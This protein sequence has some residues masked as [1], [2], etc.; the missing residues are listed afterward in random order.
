MVDDAQSRVAIPLRIADDPNGEQVVDLI[1]AALLTDDLAVQRIKA[2]D[3]RLELGRNAVFDQSRANRVLDFFE[4]LQ[5]H[6]SLCSHFLL[7]GKIGV[8]LEVTERQ[9]FELTLDQR[10]AET[11]SDG[12]VDVH[13]LARDAL[14]LFWL[15]E[16]EG[17]H[18]VKAIR[19]LHHDDANVVDHGEEHL[20]DVF[21]LALFRRHHVEAANFRHAFD[22]ARD[23]RT[24][25]FLD[26]GNREF[27]VLDHVVKQRGG[28]RG[29]VKTYVCENVSDFQ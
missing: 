14:L 22:Q 25:A 19:Q 21:G 12:T 27:G 17:P 6:G 29:G 16:F 1:E 15:E 3:A 4:E 5:V 28:K 7:Q 23:F 10:H 2:L 26:A 18:V 20:A 9:V 13:G 24:E 8:G 11:V